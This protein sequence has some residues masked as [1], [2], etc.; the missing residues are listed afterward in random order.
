M[1]EQAETAVKDELLRPPQD[2]PEPALARNARIVLERRYLHRKDGGSPLETPGGAFWRVAREV[3]R[4]SEW[5]APV[6]VDV[7][8][9]LKP[10][11]N[12][13]LA[14]IVN[15]GGVAGFVLKLA[16]TTDK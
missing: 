3:A 8:K 14:G 16:L 10:E 13:L 5:Q 4:G 9:Y 12:V 7:Q 1:V 15:Q 2:L 11:G 6:E